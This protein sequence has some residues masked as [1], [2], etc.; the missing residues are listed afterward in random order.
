M[1]RWSASRRRCRLTFHGQEHGV[2]FLA[3][4]VRRAN[5]VFAFVVGHTAFD[6]QL[7]VIPVVFLEVLRR[8]TDFGIITEPEERID[9]ET[10]NERDSFTRR[11]LELTQQ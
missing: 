7:V 1:H 4:A 5:D 6:F 9:V 2:V 8:L 3:V 11:R 10:V